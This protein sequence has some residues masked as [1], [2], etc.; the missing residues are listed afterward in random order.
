M[1]N[2]SLMHVHVNKL[3]LVLTGTVTCLL[4][5]LKSVFCHSNTKNFGVKIYCEINHH[6]LSKTNIPSF[7]KKKNL[8]VHPH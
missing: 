8:H 5:K 1:D 6:C 7:H 2:V 3:V 4:Q